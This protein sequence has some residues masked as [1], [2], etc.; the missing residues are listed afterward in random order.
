MNT[1]NKITEVDRKV[2][3]STLWIFVLLNIIF[4]DIH[5]LVT[6]EA[7][8]EIMTGVINGRQI[9]E[10]LIFIGAFIVEIPIVMVLLSRILKYSLNRWA[11]IIA[12]AVT[13]VVVVTGAITDLDD[14]FFV[15]VESVA[16]IFIIWYAWKWP[17]QEAQ[18]D[19]IVTI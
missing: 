9:S 4:R 12:G 16:L 18:V 6:A 8:Q 17:K 5:E 13:L 11:N 14:W 7:L 2:L 3:F 15:I 10:E 19:S 1:S